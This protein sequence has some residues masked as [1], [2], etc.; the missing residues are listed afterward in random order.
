M[1]NYFI[2][3]ILAIV[4]I[5]V[6][7]FNRSLSEKLGAFYSRRFAMTFGML[8]HLLKWDDPNHPFTRLLYR[9]FV[10]T[11]GIILILF[12]IAGFFGTNFGGPSTQST[13]TLLQQQ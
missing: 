5:T 6:L 12:A 11:A 13:N 2:S 10:I 8:A 1:T 4:G 9:G 3:I 7:Y